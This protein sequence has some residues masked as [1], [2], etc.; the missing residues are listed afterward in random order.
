MLKVFFPKGSLFRMDC[1]WKAVCQHET[2]ANQWALALCN[3][4]WLDEVVPDEWHEVLVTAVLKTGDV[5]QCG[6]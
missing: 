4:C 5:A 2:P 3:K 1:F 6:N